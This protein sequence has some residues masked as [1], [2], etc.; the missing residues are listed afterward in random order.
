MTDMKRNLTFNNFEL[1]EIKKIA[2]EKGRQSV[3]SDI[4]K[5]R[6]CGISETNPKTNP[7]DVVFVCDSDD[8]DDEPEL[9]FEQIGNNQFEPLTR[10][11]S[12][13]S[14]SKT[15]PPRNQWGSKENRYYRK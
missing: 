13:A 14:H 8:S 10:E 15:N 1:D 12:I 3:F 5:L 6:K 4:D 9:N 2:F 11:I 7:D